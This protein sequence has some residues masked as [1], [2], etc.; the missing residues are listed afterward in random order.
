MR[1]EGRNVKSMG[2]ARVLVSA[3]TPNKSTPTDASHTCD[4][5][6]Q[7]WRDTVERRGGE[8]PW[9]IYM[10]VGDGMQLLCSGA[11]AWVIGYTRLPTIVRGEPR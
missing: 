11:L 2:G 9:L 7:W 10:P 5:E 1:S 4:R 6:T 8:T 3:V